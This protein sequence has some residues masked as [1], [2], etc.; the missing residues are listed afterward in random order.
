M[1]VTSGV[2]KLAK[3]KGMDSEEFSLWLLNQ[4]CAHDGSNTL[5]IEGIVFKI[6]G[7]C[8]LYDI[9]AKFENETD[10]KYVIY[11]RIRE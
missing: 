2:D 3:S 9:H 5:T 10:D 1:D 6:T 11:H 4:E 8:R 7:G